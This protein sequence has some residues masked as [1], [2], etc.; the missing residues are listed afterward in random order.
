MTWESEGTGTWIALEGF[1]SGRQRTSGDP[2]TAR[3]APYTV[4]GLLIGQQVGPFRPF[5]SVENLTDVRQ[6]REAPLVLPSRTADGRW[7]TAPWGQLEGRVVS[8]GARWSRQGRPHGLSE[9]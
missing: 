9:P 4:I 7:T 3:S 6:T 2:Y 1:Y 8:V 5:V